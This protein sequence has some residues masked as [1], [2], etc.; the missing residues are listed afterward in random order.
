MAFLDSM[1][2]LP[3]IF[4][5]KVDRSTMAASLEVRVP[6]LDKELVNYC[7]RIPGREKNPMGKKKYLLK[8][9]LAGMVPDDV[10]YGKKTGFGVP[11][12]YWLRT[13]LKTLF[14]D[15]LEK[16]NNTYPSLLNNTFILELYKEHELR[17]RDRSFLLWKILSFMIWANKYHIGFKF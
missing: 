5:E 6:F 15:H 1:I 13:S 17:Y 16:F 2:I 11:Y 8:L 4:L 3:D 12:G 7:M 10:L 9:A 14:F